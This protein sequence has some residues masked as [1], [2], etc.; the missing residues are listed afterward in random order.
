MEQQVATEESLAGKRI[1]ITN[2]YFEKID[3][4]DPTVLDLMSDD[5]QF[6]FPKS[7]IRK[8]KEEWGK[9]GE[10]FGKYLKSIKHDIPQLRHIVQGNFVVVEGSEQGEMTDG[11]KWPDGKISQGLFC[12][13]FEFKGEL[14]TR[15]H[16][17]VDPDFISADQDRVK[18]LFA[19]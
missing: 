18:A 9:F 5:V 13:V 17:Y 2:V 8:G 6:F 15:L 19:E 10:L 3:N 12:N 16:V 1:A 4:W 14:I 11:T 7:G